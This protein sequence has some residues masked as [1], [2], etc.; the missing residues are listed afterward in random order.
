MTQEMDQNNNMI[1]Q[2]NFVEM[3]EKLKKMKEENEGK[4]TQ[5]SVKLK[6]KVG[7]TDL[8]SFEKIMIEK[9]DNILG[10]N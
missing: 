5:F 4:L 8:F 6:K 10:D 7:I 3:I 9:L 1:R 2:I